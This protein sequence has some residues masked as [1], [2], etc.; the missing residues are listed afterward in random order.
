MLN[1][2]IVNSDADHELI[3]STAFAILHPF[4]QIEP[5]WTLYNLTASYFTDYVNISSS[6]ISYPAI[7][8]KNFS[9]AV[10]PLPPLKEQQ[11]IVKKAGQIL[12]LITELEGRFK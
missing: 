2:A 3:A 11:R 4:E 9:L 5:Q 6:G 8:D 10:V 7:N 1:T 12:E